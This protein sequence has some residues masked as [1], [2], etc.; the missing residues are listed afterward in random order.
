MAITLSTQTVAAVKAL[1]TIEN[2]TKP[3]ETS[4]LLVFVPVASVAGLT[5]DIEAVVP[6]ST[7]AYA[8]A[9]ISDENAVAY[10]ED[11]AEA[12]ADTMQEIAYHLFEAAY[13]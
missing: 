12:A 7:K 13:C 5:E 1:A 6:A 4:A 8:I 11:T 3:F 2:S 9:V 10:L